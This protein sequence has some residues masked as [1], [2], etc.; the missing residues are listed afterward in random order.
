LVVALQAYMGLGCAFPTRPDADPRDE[1]ND[2][3]VEAAVASLDF[4]LQAP[5]AVGIRAA[6]AA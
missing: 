1:R 2:G 3:V 5:R 6:L 4:T